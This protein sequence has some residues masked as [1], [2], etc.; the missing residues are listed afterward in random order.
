MS[1]WLGQ[2]AEG[3]GVIRNEES[4]ERRDTLRAAS[5]R[6]TSREKLAASRDKLSTTRPNY[7][8]GKLT[9]PQCSHCRPPLFT[10][11]YGSFTADEALRLDRKT[12][13]D[14]FEEFLQTATTGR[15]LLASSSSA[16]SSPSIVVLDALPYLHGDSQKS[17]FHTI[18]AAA[19]SQTRVPIVLLHTDI[20]E[21]GANANPYDLELLIGKDLVNSVHMTQL[22]CNLV[23]KTAMVKALKGILAKEG[24]KV[25]GESA[26]LDFIYEESGGDI[27]SAIMALQFRLSHEKSATITSSERMNSRD[28]QVR[29]QD[30]K[31]NCAER[32][33]A[34][35]CGENVRR[36]RAARTRKRR[37]SVDGVLVVCGKRRSFTH[38]PLCSHMCGLERAARTRERAWMVFWWCVGRGG[39]SHT[40]P[41]AWLERAARRAKCTAQALLAAHNLSLLFTLPPPFVHVCVCA[42][43]ER[44]ACPGKVAVR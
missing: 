23:A 2:M 40:D 20:S 21:S 12:Q 18:L 16:S 1:D 4:E 41:F 17:K 5:G 22:R 39:C 8:N 7:P 19:V 37:A 13:L 9:A 24:I 15:S 26:L 6:A 36:E 29:V 33:A 32:R 34:R 11:V 30:T 31:A 44:L 35:T 38:R 10:H 3:P 25:K 27:R 28:L 43:D 42:A 14:E